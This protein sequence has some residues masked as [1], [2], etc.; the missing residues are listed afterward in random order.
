MPTSVFYLT[1][2]IP[3][4]HPLTCV[5]G[6]ELLLTNEA[7]GLYVILQF[8]E[9]VEITMQESWIT[10]K[11]VNVTMEHIMPKVYMLEKLEKSY[12]EHM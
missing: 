3:P 11:Y 1:T 9:D 8:A 4:L 12:G 2:I 6:F 5:E 10:N 7:I